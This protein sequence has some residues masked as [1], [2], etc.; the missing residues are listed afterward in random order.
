FYRPRVDK[1]F[2]SNH[3]IAVDTNGFVSVTV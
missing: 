1:R 2:Q 3:C